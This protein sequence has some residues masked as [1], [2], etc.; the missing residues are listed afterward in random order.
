MFMQQSYC[1]KSSIFRLLKREE[2]EN[3]KEWE[4]IALSQIDKLCQRCSFVPRPDNL[5]PPTNCPSFFVSC[6]VI[7][8]QP[9]N[10][11]HL[12]QAGHQLG[13]S[14]THHQRCQTGESASHYYTITSTPPTKEQ[15]F[16][17]CC[18]PSTIL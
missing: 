10:Q 18:L 7:A 6:A 15:V 12:S 11:Q 16:F 13:N 17:S 9:A 3:K 1:Q 8:R 5:P 4:S 2:P 14:S